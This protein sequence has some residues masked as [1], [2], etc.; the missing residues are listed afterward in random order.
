M[1]ALNISIENTVV[2]HLDTIFAFIEVWWYGFVCMC[3]CV[4]VCVCARACVGENDR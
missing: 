2:I 3:V 1:L 4:C